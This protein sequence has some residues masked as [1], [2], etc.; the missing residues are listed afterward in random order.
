MN[1]EKY[2]RLGY[3]GIVPSLSSIAA[4]KLPGQSERQRLILSQHATFRDIRR[5]QWADL[6]Q[7]HNSSRLS[8][9]RLCTALDVVDVYQMFLSR[10]P[11]SPA[12]FDELVNRLTVTALVRRIVGSQE[13]LDLG[14]RPSGTQADVANVTALYRI[15]LHRDPDRAGLEARVSGNH[16]I[17]H[18]ARTILASAEYKNFNQNLVI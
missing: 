6:R 3:G 15:L 2:E 1:E 12:V 8:P 13:Y 10:S 7:T 4:D 5:R 11:D 16:D 9:V 14:G 17:R 18:V